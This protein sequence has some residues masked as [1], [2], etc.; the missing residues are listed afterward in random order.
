MA[1][2][3]LGHGEAEHHG[4]RAWRSKATHLVVT[5]RRE[6]Q[7]K[8]RVTIY[9]LQEHTPSDRLPPTRHPLPIMLSNYGSIHELIHWW[10]QEPH[11]PITSQW[12]DPPAETSLQHRSLWGTLHFQT[13][14]GETLLW[15]WQP[16]QLQDQQSAR[17]TE[18]QENTRHIP[19]ICPD[20]LVAK[21]YPQANNK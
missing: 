16:R 20:V 12:L 4:G 17:K 3:F 18:L 8:G 15:P 21:A 7:M 10:R 6:R 14:T 5:R 9:S 11:G 2:L 19:H 1:P 13:M